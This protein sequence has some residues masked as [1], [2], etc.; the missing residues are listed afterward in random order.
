M[1]IITDKK[2]VTLEFYSLVLRSLKLLIELHYHPFLRDDE[3]EARVVSEDDRERQEN[4]N[5]ALRHA[6]GVVLSD[7]DKFEKQVSNNP[8]SLNWISLQWCR[9]AL[10][11][12][13]VLV[14]IHFKCD[15]GE[16]KRLPSL[17]KP[18]VKHLT[19]TALVSDM[20]EYLEELEQQKEEVAA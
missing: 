16:I 4:I 7:I 17:S 18:K 9:L 8:V 2:D 10:R 5:L 1:K 3:I 13:R 14:A 19:H 20:S 12:L 6:K 11:A 15:T